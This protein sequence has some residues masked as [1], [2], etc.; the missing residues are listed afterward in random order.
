M[1]PL[2]SKAVDVDNDPFKQLKDLFEIH[3]ATLRKLTDGEKEFAMQLAEFLEDIANRYL[4]IS[5]E[6][7]SHYFKFEC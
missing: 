1:S 2:V 6:I 5:E 3:H 7:Q 4:D